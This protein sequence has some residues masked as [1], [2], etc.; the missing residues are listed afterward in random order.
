MKGLKNCYAKAI[1]W[2]SSFLNVIVFALTGGYVWLKSDSEEL[3]K[4]TKKV[5]IV[6]VI[7]ICIEAVLSVI[8][9][10]YS[11]SSNYNSNFYKF[12]T[13]LSKLVVIGKI[14]TYLVFTLIALFSKEHKDNNAETQ[15]NAE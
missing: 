12:Y 11:L 1:L 8:Y 6:A 5:F 2:I 15:T 4:E 7:F 14:V 3:K 10:I 13:T 9:A